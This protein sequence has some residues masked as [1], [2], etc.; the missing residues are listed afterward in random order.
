MN[1]TYFSKACERL[2]GYSAKEAIGRECREIFK[3]NICENLCAI[4][5]SARE[6]R[7]VLNVEIEM[8]NKRTEIV[9]IMASASSLKD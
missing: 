4:K 8:K 6:D 9:P 1:I 2:T 3:S 5:R 7:P